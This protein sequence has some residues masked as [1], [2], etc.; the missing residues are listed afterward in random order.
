MVSNMLEEY[1]KSRWA[2]IAKEEA[3]PRN[4]NI[5]KMS[6]QSSAGSNLNFLI[7]PGSALV[8][9]YFVKQNRRPGDFSGIEREYASLVDIRKKGS[10]YFARTTPE[11][12]LIAP[13]DDLTM[14]MVETF[15]PLR[16]ASAANMRELE[17]LFSLSFGWLKEFYSAT[18]IGQFRRWRELVAEMERRADAFKAQGAKCGYLDRLLAKAK[19]MEYGDMPLCALQ[20]DFSI[21]NMVIGDD[22]FAIVDWED[23]TSAA[24]PFLDIEFLIF[25]IALSF[26]RGGNACE[27]FKRFFGT[28]SR[29]L[30]ITERYLKTYA[31]HLNI[32]R[33]VFYIAAVNDTLGIISQGYGRHEIVHMQDADFL[34]ALSN[35]ALR[36]IG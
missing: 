28:G 6:G 35:I 2:V 27:N 13:L 9:K 29:T 26:H 15:L 21:N 31:Q 8:P 3:P 30:E 12:L 24:L 34:E 10:G 14:V 25:H 17:N 33:S 18:K 20:G 16:R 19:K 22:C 1:L 23:Y 32:D 5:I 11:P 4:I 36:Q 7:F